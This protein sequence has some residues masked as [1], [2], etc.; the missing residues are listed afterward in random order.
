MI[1]YL[2]GFHGTLDSWRPKRTADG[3]DKL[4]NEEREEDQDVK[5]PPRKRRRLVSP[6]TGAVEEDPT[7]VQS[8]LSNYSD[9]KLGLEDEEDSVEEEDSCDLEFSTR[10]AQAT[11]DHQCQSQL[12][13]EPERSDKRGHDDEPPARVK[14]TTRL[15]DD[16]DA[17]MK[18]TDLARV[19]SKFIT[20][21]TYG[22]GDASGKGYG[23][24]LL[25]WDGVI[26]YRQGLWKWTIIKE[27]SSNYRELRNLVDG[28]ERAAEKGLLDGTEVWMF[29][30]NTTA[31][32]A[33][34]RG[35][36]KSRELHKLVLCLRVLEMKL[37]VRI[38][39]VH[40]SGSR[41]IMTGIDGVSR[42]DMNAGVMAGADMLSFVSQNLSAMH[43][44]PKLTNWLQSWVG[45]GANFLEPSQWPKI[46][47]NHGTYVWS[48]PPA[49]APAALE[50][51]DESVHKR[52]T[53]VHV[54]VI[55]RLLTALWRK[56]L[57]NI[58]DLMLTVPLGCPAWQADNLEPL[59][60]AISLPLSKSF[61]WR[62][63]NTS[64]T[65]D[66][67]RRVPPMWA[68]SCFN[69]IGPALRK[70]LLKARNVSGV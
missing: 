16:V 60:L 56:Q 6:A 27:R 7:E 70:L 39:V 42:G 69:D 19:R 43:R 66:V 29:T 4:L 52:P 41:M 11:K 44:S 32:A 54:I 61:P 8:D 30:D 22:F 34:F 49:A 36:S 38:W 64:T 51:L 46:H 31:E 25:L 53:S 13:L 12:P 17:L 63:R 67:E 23:A 21:L 45:D 58:T 3:F 68:T 65:H 14:F 55:P 50:W 48:P 35:S 20:W 2:R 40:V 59:I 15:R 47:E 28:L 9:P 1:P 37:G 10:A 5:L 24:A 57:G 33:F 26:F 18:L 62:F